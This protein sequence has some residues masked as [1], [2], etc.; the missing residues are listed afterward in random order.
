MNTELL[1]KV[2]RHILA[3]P[4]RLRMSNWIIDIERIAHDS[5]TQLIASKTKMDGKPAFS[6]VSIAYNEPAAQLIPSCGT[7]G[8]I[9]GWVCILE[10]FQAMEKLGSLSIPIKAT[11]LLQISVR[12]ADHLF[13]VTGWPS[14]FRE[15]YIEGP[16][17][18]AKQRAKIVADRIDFFI[19]TN[20]TDTQ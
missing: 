8:C 20:G 2:R 19:K 17:K 18:T 6:F 16:T 7:V 9:A 4:S 1:R 10:G 14:P 11:Q 15:Q 13:Y 3:K 12:E 5:E